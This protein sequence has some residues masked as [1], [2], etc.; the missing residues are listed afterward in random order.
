MITLI[1]GDDIDQARNKLNEVLEGKTRITR[2]NFEKATPDE[3]IQAFE[4]QDLFEEK[5]TIVIENIKNN[6]LFDKILDALLSF[7][8]NP[9]VDI[10]LWADEALDVKFVA[11][12]K[13][14]QSY[15]FLLPKFLF[16]F[17]DTLLPNQGKKSVELLSKVRDGM[18]DELIFFMIVKRIRTLLLLKAGNSTDF[19]ETSRMQSWQLSRMSGQL[20]AWDE[21]KLVSFYQKLFDLETGMKTSTLPLSLGQ[22]LDILLLSDLN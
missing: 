12:L 19:D 7:K 9:M 5:R 2:I 21:K 15:A 18:A 4:S 10:V 14:A 8:K 16:P 11:K 6:A 22:H 17:L 13:D 20:N 3:L 1:Y